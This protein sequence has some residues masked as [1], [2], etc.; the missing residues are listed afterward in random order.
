MYF[1][2]EAERLYLIMEKPDSAI[3]MYKKAKR[4]EPM[5][6]LVATYHP[7]LLTD[8]HLHLAKV[9]EQLVTVS[10]CCKSLADKHTVILCCILSG[11]RVGGAVSSS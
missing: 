11:A 10:Y 8:T 3:S 6:K 2:V 1:I 5:V 4:Y 7:D 9:E